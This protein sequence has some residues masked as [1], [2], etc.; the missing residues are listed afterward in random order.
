MFPTCTTPFLAPSITG[1][2]SSL[3]FGVP[4]TVTCTLYRP[5]VCLEMFGRQHLSS[6]PEYHVLQEANSRTRPGAD[7]LARLYQLDTSTK[8]LP[9]WSSKDAL[10]QLY[11][12]ERRNPCVDV[13][14]GATALWQD[15]L[16]SAFASCQILHHQDPPVWSIKRKQQDYRNCTSTALYYRL[17]SILSSLIVAGR[18]PVGH[19]PGAD[20]IMTQQPGHP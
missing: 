8:V 11:H 10:Y 4:G 9:F 15:D 13:N 2:Q 14:L 1:V 7:D 6:I 3:N 20:T 19:A 17:R 18:Q 16:A 5:E 12:L